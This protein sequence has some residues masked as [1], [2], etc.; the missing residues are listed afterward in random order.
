MKPNACVSVVIPA[1][2]AV[3]TISDTLKSVFAQTVDPH[4]LEIIL[5]NDGSTDA[6]RTV[7]ATLLGESCITWQIIDVP[8]S[9]PSVARNIGF[10]AAK[11]EW[12]QF[13]DAD[14]VIAPSK[15]PVQLSSAPDDAAVVYSCW[16]RVQQRNGQWVPVGTVNRPLIEGDTTVALLRS[17]NFIATGSQIFRRTWLECVGGFNERR[18]FIEDVELLLRISVASGGFVNVPS[19]LPLFFY[20]ENEHSLSRSNRESFVDGCVE[21]TKLAEIF[22][23]ENFAILSQAQ[24]DVLIEAYAEAARFYYEHSRAKFQAT[25]DRLLML[26]PAYLPSRPK[27]LRAFSTMLG[28]PRAEAV[29]LAYRKVKRRLLNNPGY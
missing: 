21:N 2:N 7:S 3:R 15:L 13:L 19:D 9:G 28:Y 29:A 16:Q 11:G 25:Y 24:S 4:V 6:T 18:R 27:K 22:W 17:E 10:R 12:I 20:R 26:D 23:R 5:V 14:D 8:N 1:F